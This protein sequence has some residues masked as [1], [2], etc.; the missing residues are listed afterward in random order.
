MRR[1]ILALA[2]LLLPLAPT[3]AKPAPAGRLVYFGTHGA[4]IY[5]AWLNAE[6]GHLSDLGAVAE[7]ERPTWLAADPKRPLLY[8]VSET[9][10]DGKTQATVSSF[11]IDTA[12]GALRLLSKVESGGGGATHLALDP[13]SHTLF[14]A[15]FGTGQVSALPVRPD[16]SLAPVASVQADYGSGPSPRQKGPHAHGVALDPSGRF[17]LAADLGADRVFVYRFDPVTRAL[18]PSEPAFVASA[19]GSGPR[20]LAFLPNGKVVYLDTEL[21]G[22][23]TRFAWDSRTGTLRPQ[24]TIST[25][26]PDYTGP[27]SAAELAVSADGRFLYVSNRGE[28]SLVVYAIQPATGALREV[29]RIAAQGKGPW[30]FSLDPSGRWILIANEASSAIAV[31][32]VDPAT[33]LL[34]A[35]NESL[36]VPKPVSIAFA[37]R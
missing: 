17:L 11:A 10:N 12:T 32:K 24:A 7:I 13:R 30:S 19:P 31:L 23:I 29:Q 8:S 27:R 4:A 5:A 16:G 26:A 18:T 3:G 22:E 21:S 14:V 25:G 2:A 6:T 34:R 37:P 28:D 33:G 20:H 36:A 9:G 1:L 35:T 15:H